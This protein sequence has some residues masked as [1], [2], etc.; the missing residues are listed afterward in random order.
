MSEMDPYAQYSTMHRGEMRS[1]R[2]R[3]FAWL[4]G[5][6]GRRRTRHSFRG[7][8]RSGTPTSGDRDPTRHLYRNRTTGFP[9]A[10][11]RLTSI[12]PD[13]VRKATRQALHMPAPGLTYA[14]HRCLSPP[15]I[16]YQN[17]SISPL[18][19]RTQFLRTL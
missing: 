13:L 16:Q 5:D 15:A 18:D 1:R 3:R 2:V 14:P 4:G 12:G 8:P 19:H 9:R 17:V 7:L 6:V 10:C 11:L